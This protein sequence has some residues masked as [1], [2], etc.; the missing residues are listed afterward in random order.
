MR[1]GATQ[2]SVYETIKEINDKTQ[3]ELIN[4]MTINGFRTENNQPIG[5]VQM[6]NCIS[7][8]LEEGLIAKTIKGNRTTYFNDPLT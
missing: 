1:L 4:I 3:S 8:L 6:S 2:K 7:A 5:K